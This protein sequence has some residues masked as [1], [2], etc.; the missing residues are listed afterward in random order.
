MLALAPSEGPWRSDRFMRDVAR[1]AV[2][3]G[4]AAGLGVVAGFLIALNVLETSLTE[5]RTVAVTTLI[6]IGLYFVLIL[7]GQ[8]ATA[9]R[10]R[11]VSL[12]CGSCWWPT[13]WPSAGPR[14]AS[15]SRST[16]PTRSPSPPR[17]CAALAIGGLWITD[18]RFAPPS[19]RLRA[20][21][22]RLG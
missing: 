3:A 1:F 5:A 10:L 19:A 18:D 22:A 12:L 7:E 17:C 8:G 14:R 6:L 2:P 9:R 21:A 15:S 20:L 16:G 13:P 11:W 4:V